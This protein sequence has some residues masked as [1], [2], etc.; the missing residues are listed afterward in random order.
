MNF[1]YRKKKEKNAIFI[2]PSEHTE[3]GE[4]NGILG[5]MTFRGRTKKNFEWKLTFI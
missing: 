2:L 3:K 4:F 1:L 5:V